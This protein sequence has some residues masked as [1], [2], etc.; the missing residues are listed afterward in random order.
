MMESDEVVH[1]NV[2]EPPQVPKLNIP[3]VFPKPATQ[4]VGPPMNGETRVKCNLGTTLVAAGIWGLRSPP[5]SLVRAG[6]ALEVDGEATE[7][8]WRALSR[9]SGCGGSVD[10]EDGIE[11][12]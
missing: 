6:S 9:L 3:M 4:K 5:G 11:D 8:A 1:A 10:G 2:E 12:N 7:D